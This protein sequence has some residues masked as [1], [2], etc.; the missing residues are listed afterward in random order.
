MSC[1]FCSIRDE[2]A[3]HELAVDLYGEV[4]AQETKE[5]TKVAYKVRHV[6]IPR[7]ADCHSRH[8]IVRYIDLFS[9]F[10]G[11]VFLLSILFAVFGWIAQWI[12]ALW[13]GLSF[14][15]LLGS[16]AAHVLIL[17][18]THS[19]YRAKTTFPEIKELLEKCYRFGCRPKGQ[20][21]ESDPACHSAEANQAAPE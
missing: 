4:A 17:R 18:G 2:T 14:G 9:I 16:L 7:C 8:N 15:L 3:E 10:L 1:W 21:I 13:M 6:R 20:V 5:Q 12:W 11:A 19:V